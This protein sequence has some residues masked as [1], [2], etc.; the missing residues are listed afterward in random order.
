MIFLKKS[1]GLMENSPVLLRGIKIGKVTSIRTTNSGLKAVIEVDSDIKVTNNSKITI[2]NLSI[3]GEQYLNFE[4]LGPDGE[5]LVDGSTISADE[6]TSN[7]SIGDVFPKVNILNQAIDPDELAEIVRTLTTSIKG[8]EEN[9]DKISTAIQLF[10][11]MI[12]DKHETLRALISDTSTL[13]GKSTDLNVGQ[14]LAETGEK[15]PVFAENLVQLVRS[16]EH[17]SYVASDIWDRPLIE[18][19]NL[20]GGYLATYLPQLKQFATVIT[21]LTSQL[22]PAIV[23]AGSIIDLLDS[24][25]NPDGSLRLVLK[26]QQ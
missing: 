6:V 1:D 4:P 12:G 20:V 7:V 19:V 3:A 24:A 11:K 23:H 2:A 8:E 16:F 22:H 21:P 14:T 17:Y 10:T 25:F 9:L 13:V 5:D 15:I 18:L 26:A